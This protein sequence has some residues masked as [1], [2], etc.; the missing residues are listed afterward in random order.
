MLPSIGRNPHISL[1]GMA[2]GLDTD[3]I[4][5]DLMHIERMKTDRFEQSRIRLEWRRDAF[6]NFNRTL[7]DMRAKYASVMS[8]DNML[9]PAVF[10]NFK[11]E[12]ANNGSL[13]VTASAHARTGTHNVSIQQIAK[14]ST[15]ETG[16]AAANNNG[17]T[18][19]TINSTSLLTL[20]NNGSFAS[21]GTVRTNL[22]ADGTARGGFDV[23]INGTVIRLNHNMSMRQIMD[24]V[25][26]SD[27]GVNMSYSQFT[28]SFVL[29]NTRMGENGTGRFE[30]FNVINSTDAQ[31]EEFLMG[32]KQENNKGFT[33]AQ[34]DQLA[35]WEAAHRGNYNSSA[36]IGQIAVYNA[37]N[38]TNFR[39]QD[40]AATGLARDNLQFNET[41]GQVCTLTNRLQ[42][43]GVSR[44][45]FIALRDL[46][47][48]DVNDDKFF[49]FIPRLDGA[50]EPVLD[51][52]DEPI[53][54]RIFNQQKLDDE[55]F[56][57]STNH[58]H[59]TFEQVKAES[60]LM[61]NV[62]DI[63]GFFQLIGFGAFDYT[64]K[65]NL[66]ANHNPNNVNAK[67]NTFTTGTFTATSMNSKN[68][69]LRVNGIDIVRNTNNIEADGL[70]L[71]LL[72]VTKPANGTQPAEVITFTV[73]QNVSETMDK[74]KQFIDSVNE[75]MRELHTKINQKTDRNF[76]PLTQMYKDQ[77]SEV[78]IAL[79]ETKAKEGLLRRDPL[80]TRFYDTLVRSITENIGGLGSMTSI[81]I[82][83]GQFRL[84]EPAQFEIDPVV[85]E[86]A[87][88]DEPDR[89]ASMFT[90]VNPDDPDELKNRNGGW[91][92][93]FVD[94]LDSFV[95]STRARGGPL[96][97]IESQIT[98]AN[99]RLADRTRAMERSE[100]RYRR[101]FVAMERALAMMNSQQDAVGSLAMS[102][103]AGAR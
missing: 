89:V 18:A 58:V 51:G 46:Y 84:G 7:N 78:E 34:K 74:I 27:A 76:F 103:M 69:Q 8:P 47:N 41:A 19:Q 59:T 11:V 40:V 17:F 85:L 43:L 90:M 99:R 10:K 26:S 63:S 83:T 98:E 80:L 67:A 5:R 33:V 100:Q 42:A 31:F 86:K 3:A 72:D 71:N 48:L 30:N 25:N 4:I 64:D 29:E 24:T 20:M 13:A 12:M 39:W 28:N 16:K 38:N 101:Q 77:M 65:D 21:G 61:L 92:N 54:D 95:S 73:T 52:D 53:I 102:F 70:T 88:R 44:E 91:V 37:Q 15:L 45:D 82:T 93:R 22:D 81:G 87:L 49:D 32:I 75:L 2:S 60:G 55:L 94:A 36:L 79:W 62:H 23:F 35:A 57:I 68:A 66:P 50:G 6:T 14:G 96:N 56:R 9:S 1:A 97:A